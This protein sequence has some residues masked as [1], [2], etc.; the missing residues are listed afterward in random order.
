MYC[1]VLGGFQVQKCKLKGLE[2]W[3]ESRV[4]CDVMAL[5]KPVVRK[6]RVIEA[7]AEESTGEPILTLEITDNKSPHVYIKGITM[8][9]ALRHIIS[10]FTRIPKLFFKV[11]F[12]FICVYFI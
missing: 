4:I 9:T 10:G 7:M 6:M 8:N 3:D 2:L 5:L 11:S 12:Y 1:N